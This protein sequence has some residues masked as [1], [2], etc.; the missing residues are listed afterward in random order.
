MIR[1]SIPGLF[2]VLLVVTAGCLGGGTPDAAPTVDSSGGGVDSG[3]S[4]GSGDGG[5]AGGDGGVTSGDA[6][7]LVENRTAALMEAGSYTSVWRMR[8]LEDGAQ[9]GEMAYTTKV[10]YA[11]ERFSFET[12]STSEG[13]T[14]T[15]LASYFADGKAYQRIGEGDGATYASSDAA[16]GTV[17][18]PGQTAY[19]SAAGD[20]EEFTLAGTETFDGVRVKRYEMKKAAP[21]LAAQRGTDG[22]IRWTD[23]S[24]AVL[25]DERGL[26]RSERWQGTGVD[27]AGTK[28]TIEFTYELTG[29]GRTEV[30]EP[31]W[32][33][34]ARA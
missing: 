13:K 1:T 10:D 8:T 5:A 4:A 29:V 19:V 2:V 7:T 11:N 20:L 31:A 27:D 25:V 18:R 24:Y 14:R 3:G 33:D 21:W 6:A 22:E 15:S 16:F 12:K 17:A 30:P 32:L 23:F 9:V 34:R 28:K 26:V